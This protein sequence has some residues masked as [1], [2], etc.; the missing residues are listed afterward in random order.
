LDQHEALDSLTTSSLQQNDII[1]APVFVPE[2]T[3]PHMNLPTSNLGYLQL[4][5][6]LLRPN[7][8]ADE[9]IF[10]W[11]SVN[12]PP[13][14]TINVPIIQLIAEIT[15]CT[16]LHDTSSYGSGLRK[17]HIFCDIFS[18]PESD[19]LPA[20]FELLH[21]FAIWAT[22]EPSLLNPNIASTAQFEPISVPVV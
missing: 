5:P 10:L 14:T 11:R 1:V 13:P 18:I 4:L 9:Q 16:S 19:R 6:S 7:C 17:F 3:G 15:S 22:T 2:N 21:S 8:K 12:K 20:S